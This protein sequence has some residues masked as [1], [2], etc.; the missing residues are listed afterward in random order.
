M[1]NK[2]KECK[3]TLDDHIGQI[4]KSKINLYKAGKYV[5]QLSCGAE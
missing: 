1:A 5:T 4:Q 3:D 2:I